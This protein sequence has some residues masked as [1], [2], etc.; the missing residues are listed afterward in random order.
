[1]AQWKCSLTFFNRNSTGLPQNILLRGAKQVLTLHGPEGA[2]RGSALKEVS[3]IQD[4]SVLICEGLIKCVGS[5]RRIENLR[6]ARQAFE[7]DVH[8]CLV[9]PG[10]VDPGLSAT[11]ERIRLPGHRLKTSRNIHEDNLE[12]MR[13]C[14]QH[15]TLTAE[16]KASEPG[17]FASIVPLLRQLAKLGDHPVDLLRTW[18]VSRLPESHDEAKEFRETVEMTR[19]R[20]LVHF[21]EIPVKAMLGP[22]REHVAVLASLGVPLKIDC[23][24]GGAEHLETVLGGIDVAGVTCSTWASEAEAQIAAAHA[25]VVLFSPGSDIAQACGR[26]MRSVIDHGG[27]IALTSGYNGREAPGHSMQNAICRAVGLGQLSVE[28]AIGAATVNAAYA[29]GLGSRTGTLEAGKSADIAVLAIPDYRELPRHFGIN[30]VRL[31]LRRG[32]VAFNRGRWK[33]GAHEPSAGGVRSEH[34]RRA[35]SQAG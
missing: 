4:G 15:G 25:R 30:Q 21:I 9:M 33:I 16:M 8:G 19:R 5:T 29:L 27:A 17:K 1:V 28:E 10:F 13:S 3:A 24:E 23:S 32:Q 11:S 12:L 22:D 2:R 34:L 14:L 31:V 7:I 18:K 6:E 35:K 26:A 20:K